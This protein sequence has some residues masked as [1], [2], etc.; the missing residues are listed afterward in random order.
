ME[1]WGA[2][3]FNFFLISWDDFYFEGWA[4]P[5][6]KWECGLE[7]IARSHVTNHV[8]NFSRV[9]RWLLLLTN[10]IQVNYHVSKINFKLSKVLTL[11]NWPQ[12]TPRIS[13]SSWCTSCHKQILM[14]SFRT[15]LCWYNLQCIEVRVLGGKASVGSHIGEE[16]HLGKSNIQ[17]NIW[18]IVTIFFYFNQIGDNGACCQF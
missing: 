10:H 16:N 11:K 3:F 1:G 15:M 14:W 4:A 18:T 9:P 8:G 6:K 5:G 12:G 2:P 13:I 7:A 17:R